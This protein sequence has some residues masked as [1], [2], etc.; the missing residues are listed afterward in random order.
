MQIGHRASSS[1]KRGGFAAPDLGAVAPKAKPQTRW[2]KTKLDQTNPMDALHI[3]TRSTLYT[4]KIQNTSCQAVAIRRQQRL[5]QKSFVLLQGQC[6]RVRQPCMSWKPSNAE[7]PRHY[8]ILQSAGW[9]HF[10]AVI[11]GM[12]E[13]SQA[14]TETADCL[15]RCNTI[16]CLPFAENSCQ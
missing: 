16:G 9:L 7:T 14:K 15:K 1:A 3:S 10:E 6:K 12:C 8:C 11:W 4:N 13:R 5:F 2:N